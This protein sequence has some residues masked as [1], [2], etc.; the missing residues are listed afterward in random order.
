MPNLEASFRALRVLHTARD[1]FKQYGFHKVG[2]DRIIAESKI[3]KATFYNYFHSK[4]RLIEM[5]LT[6]QKDGLKEEVF[7]I[8]YSYRELMV[9]DKLKKIF[10]LHANL[11]GLYRLPLQAIFEIEKFYPTAYKVVVD[12]RNWLVTQIHQLLLTIKATATLEDAYMFL[13][14]IDRAMV[15][16]LS[17]DRIDERDKLL[18]YFLI[19]M[20]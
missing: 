19:M 6:F 14:V 8:I 1:L 5:C 9:F 15:Q 2:V 4:E 17:K 10:F 20:S 18:D 13:F 11:E 12:Y 7:S 16:L 3:T